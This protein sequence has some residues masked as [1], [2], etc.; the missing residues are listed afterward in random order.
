[1]KYAKC[2]LTVSAV[3]VGMVVVTNLPLHAQ[4]MALRVNIPFEFHAGEKTLPAGTYIVEK[5]GDALLISDRKGNAAGVIANAIKNKAYG[6]ESM[7]VFNRYGNECFLKEVRWSDT[8][9]ARGVIETKAE[10][11]LANVIPAEPV[12]LAANI[13]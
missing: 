3:L 13:R 4:T 11:R 10:R 1:M 5:R 2:L 7:V 8:S 6:L 12:K 9:T